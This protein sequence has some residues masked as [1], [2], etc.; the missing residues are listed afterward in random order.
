MIQNLILGD[1]DMGTGK[2]SS[3]D[4]TER[5]LNVL[6]TTEY[7][8][9]SPGNRMDILEWLL[10]ATMMLP[11]SL[12]TLRNLCDE[13]MSME[14]ELSKGSTRT[15]STRSTFDRHARLGM[16]KTKLR[17]K[18]SFCRRGQPSMRYHLLPADLVLGPQKKQPYQAYAQVSAY[19]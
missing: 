9:I 7:A 17:M 13:M 18:S 19:D 11:S 1:E 4:T 2:F 6:R 5:V 8:V 14:E 10:E 12:S 3:I 15:R 16:L